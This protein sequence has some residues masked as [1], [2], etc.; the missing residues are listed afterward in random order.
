M[1]LDFITIA[2][3]SQQAPHDHKVDVNIEKQATRGEK[4]EKPFMKR[5]WAY[6]GETWS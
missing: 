4:E 3:P 5:L 1:I 6:Y 2:H